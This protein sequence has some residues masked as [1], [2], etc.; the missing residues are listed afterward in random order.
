MDVGTKIKELRENAGLTQESLAK[1]LMIAR[2]T[3]ACYEI[4]KNQVPN[5]LLVKIAKHFKISTDFL[6]GLED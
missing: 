1:K 3:L 2:S 5:E 4:N 6:L